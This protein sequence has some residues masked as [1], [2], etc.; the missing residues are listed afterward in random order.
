MIQC[1]TILSQP[2]QLAWLEKSGRDCDS[3]TYLVIAL[4]F[5]K[6]AKIA[7]AGS[8]DTHTSRAT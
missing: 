4:A 6:C 2:T 5:L 8:S 7:V 1:Q 3:L